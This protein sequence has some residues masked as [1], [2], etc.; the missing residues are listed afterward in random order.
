MV[1]MC[2]CIHYLVSDQRIGA[3]YQGQQLTIGNTCNKQLTNVIAVT[4]HNAI[5]YY[6]TCNS[7]NG[8]YP[9]KVRN[10]AVETQK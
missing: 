9:N 5:N 4:L 3:T 7:N 10:C 8:I 6:Y 1:Y 2:T